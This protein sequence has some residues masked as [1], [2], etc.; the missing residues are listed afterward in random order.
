MKDSSDE[1]RRTLGARETPT[2]RAEPTQAYG[3]DDRPQGG[4][5][6]L[7]V[8][9]AASA[10]R[11]GTSPTPGQEWGV[12]PRTVEAFLSDERVAAIGRGPSSSTTSHRLDQGA[13]SPLAAP[14][15]TTG[16]SPLA[17][18]LPLVPASDATPA[19][20]LM[21]GPVRLVRTTAAAITASAALTPVEPV[22]GEGAVVAAAAMDPTQAA[23]DAQIAHLLGADTTGAS[24]LAGIDAASDATYDFDEYVFLRNTDDPYVDPRRPG[25]AQTLPVDPR[26]TAFTTTVRLWVGNFVDDAE[27]QARA[28]GAQI[29][30]VVS[31]GL[32]DSLFS[33]WAA[34]CSVRAFNQLALYNPTDIAAQKFATFTGLSPNVY[35]AYCLYSRLRQFSTQAAVQ[36]LSTQ[37]DPAAIDALMT[38]GFWEQMHHDLF[39]VYFDVPGIGIGGDDGQEYSFD[40]FPADEVLFGLQVVHRQSWQL[41]A[42]GRGELVKSIPLGPRESQKVS[43]KMTTRTKVGRGSEDTSSY[44][45]TTESST[46]TKDTAE[47][48]AEASS[49]LNKHAE[50]EVSGGFGPFIQAKVSGGIAEEQADSSR[51]TKSRLNEVMS[52]TAGRMKRDT[53]VTVSTESEDTYEVS[54]SSELTNPNDELAV[55]YL[56]HRLQQRYWVSTQIAEVHSV[57]FVPELVPQ[58]HAIDETWIARHADVLV[59]A[60]LDPGLAGVLSAIRKEPATLPTATSSAFARAADSSIGATDNYRNYTGQGTVPDFLASGQQYLERDLERQ[61]QRDDDQARRTHQTEA[62]VAHVR[63]NIL[64][65]MRAIWRSEDFDQRIQRYARRRVPTQWVFVPRAPAQPGGQPTPLEA[66]GVFAPV[67]GSERPLNQVIDPIGPIGY[68]FNCAIYRLRDDVRLAN[69]H[70]ALAWLR[71]A[72]ARFAVSCTLSADSGLTVRQAVAVAPRAFRDDLKIV[73]RQNRGKWLLPIAGRAESDW[74]ELARPVDGMIEVAG[75]RIWLDGA[76]ADGSEL[77]IKVAVTSELE[78]PQ[79]RMVRAT[80]PLPASA[81]EAQV[82]SPAVLRQMQALLPEVAAALGGATAW[83]ALTPAQ[84]DAVR[85]GYHESIVQRDSGRLVPL[86]TDNVVLDLAASTTPLLEPFKRL[87]RYID[88]V[89]ERENARRTELD[90]ARRK[91]LLDAGRLGDPDIDRVALVSAQPAF[92]DLV[93]TGA[94]TDDAP[95][96]IPAADVP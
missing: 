22:A 45:T 25:S 3:R 38:A 90:N 60:V 40:P 93:E 75:V 54:R 9:L 89:R 16:V 87:H 31:D 64:H 2:P 6:R 63:R 66:D 72:Y 70:Q 82:F 47:V 19:P 11:L 73:Y 37:G 86:E 5:R 8:E 69:T 68:L 32:V 96:D 33:W 20:G 62:L 21:F 58:A 84:Q 65:Y 17:G 52:K 28:A 18:T 41:L 30:K 94:E 91:A 7:G 23:F 85:A 77:T 36:F 67:T 46:S 29:G 12:T 1:P 81:D 48:V 92:A 50:A 35:Y 79:V 15:S 71:A 13:R 78:D 27:A 80:E 44:E 95:G 51:D 57:V 53:K 55:T 74:L 49:K 34:V 14:T 26:M 61:T 42:Y 56:Y 4:L 10:G 88:V 59:S 76:P 39:D 83:A 43:V 24:V